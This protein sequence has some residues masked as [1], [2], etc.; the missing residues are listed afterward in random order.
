M[1]NVECRMSGVERSSFDLSTFGIRHSTFDIPMV[2]VNV[3]PR[4]SSL[5]TRISPPRA[6]AIRFAKARP[7]PVPP[8]RR[9]IDA[10]TWEKGLNS[11]AILSAGMPIPVSETLTHNVECRMSNVELGSRRSA[12][13]NRHSTF[14][15]Q[16]SF[17]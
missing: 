15:S 1:S 10:L 4:L 12:F 7:S 8:N 2:N 17:D 6:L 9:V 3:L 5:A 13:G 11:I 14:S 16:R